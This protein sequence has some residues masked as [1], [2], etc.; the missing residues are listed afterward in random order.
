MG[1]VQEGGTSSCRV[2]ASAAPLR[3]DHQA[4]FFAVLAVGW[5]AF[6]AL[7]FAANSCFT[8]A[9]MASVSAL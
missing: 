6:F 8:L 4:A 2:A 7:Y 9:A 1:K 5:N 3:M